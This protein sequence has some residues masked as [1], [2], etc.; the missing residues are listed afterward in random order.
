MIRKKKNYRCTIEMGKNYIEQIKNVNDAISEEE[1]SIKLY[2]LAKYC[3]S[4]T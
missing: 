3:E 2:R 1:I 4:N